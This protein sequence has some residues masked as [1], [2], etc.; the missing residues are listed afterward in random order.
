MSEI[1]ILKGCVDGF[2]DVSLN[3]IYFI[4]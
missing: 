1:D 4:L 2:S 3:F